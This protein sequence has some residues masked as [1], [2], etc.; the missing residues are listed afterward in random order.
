M[1]SS[2]RDR[3]MIT[4]VFLY[5][6]PKKVMARLDAL[7]THGNTSES[8]LQH[9]L[10]HKLIN[11]DCLTTTRQA[12]HQRRSVAAVKGQCFP[13]GKVLKREETRVEAIA[14]KDRGACRDTHPHTHPHMHTPVE[15]I[16]CFHWDDFTENL[17]HILFH[18]FLLYFVLGNSH[19][20]V[21]DS[22]DQFYLEHCQNNWISWMLFI[23]QVDIAFNDQSHLFHIKI[24]R[25]VLSYSMCQRGIN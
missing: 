4:G 21:T 13:N 1:F 17:F 20:R 23:G 7:R 14:S 25:C 11:P 22:Q 8:V 10:T 16:K 2:P 15:Q 24:T 12:L 5:P 6:Q 18:L 9:W 19:C 3:S